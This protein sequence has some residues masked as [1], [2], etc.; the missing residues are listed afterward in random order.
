MSSIKMVNLM[1]E[2]ETEFELAIPGAD[3]TP[4]NFES[5]ASIEF[6]IEKL[7]GSSSGL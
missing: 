3:I 2:I 6:L 7:R 4:D 1:L 5:I